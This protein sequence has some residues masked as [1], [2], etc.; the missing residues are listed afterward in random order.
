[1]GQ[2]YLISD[3][4]VLKAA[5]EDQNAVL[6][7]TTIST[8]IERVLRVRHRPPATAT[9]AKPSQGVIGHDTTKALFMPLFIDDYNH[10]MGAVDHNDQLRSY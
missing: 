2:T 6:F 9:N 5:W 4:E 7:M 1:M 8:G 10:L 3:G